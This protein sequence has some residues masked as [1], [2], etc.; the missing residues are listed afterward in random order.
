M[1]D[2]G[3]D[4]RHCHDLL[5]KLKK[6]TEGLLANQSA[7]GPWGTYGALRRICDDAEAILCHRLLRNNV[8]SESVRC[9]W[10][11]IQGLKWL[12]PNSAQVIDKINRLNHSPKTGCSEDFR[13]W[14]WESV[15]DHSLIKQLDIL[16]SDEEHLLYHYYDDAFLCQPRYREAMKICFKA[17]E[18]NKPALLA[19]ISPQLLKSGL[20]ESVCLEKN[21]IPGPREPH[22]IHLRKSNSD[23]KTAMG[24]R[25]SHLNVHYSSHLSSSNMSLAVDPSLGGSS[26]LQQK[27]L[28]GPCFV[29]SLDSPSLLENLRSSDPLTDAMRSIQRSSTVH[30]APHQAEHVQ[31]R[32]H[33]ES[34]G[35]ERPHKTQITPSP[36]ET[37]DRHHIYDGDGKACCSL[38][39]QSTKNSPS[40]DIMVSR[41]KHPESD[42][43]SSF[44]D[45]SHEADCLLREKSDS[46]RMEDSIPEQRT[47]HLSL[48]LL[49]SPSMGSEKYYNTS[50]HVDI[51]LP[52]L[53]HASSTSLGSSGGQGNTSQ[54]SESYSSQQ[55]FSVK[56]G[57]HLSI[58]IDAT[59]ALSSHNID[60]SD[61]SSSGFNDSLDGL[62]DP[63]SKNVS[64][65]GKKLANPKHW[66]LSNSDLSGG[67]RDS[68]NPINKSHIFLV[69]SDPSL[70][71]PVNLSANSDMETFQSWQC[72]KPTS[73]KPWSDHD[74]YSMMSPGTSPVVKKA[75]VSLKS[76]GNIYIPQNIQ[77]AAPSDP[78]RTGSLSPDF[79]EHSRP[80]AVGGNSN[81]SSA[82]K[83]KSFQATSQMLQSKKFAH[84]RW[85]SDT[86][87]IKIE[88][89]HSTGSSAG[90]KAQASSVFGGKSLRR[91][92]QPNGHKAY[93]GRWALKD[94]FIDSLM[95]QVYGVV[96]PFTLEMSRA[97]YRPYEN[98]IV[99]GVHGV[100]RGPEQRSSVMFCNFDVLGPRDVVCSCMGWVA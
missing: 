97:F 4:E 3:K 40:V 50:S 19:E 77:P 42:S 83:T 11:F 72:D 60:E 96:Y 70:N 65:R 62:Q 75:P 45:I 98:P 81:N 33:R 61:Q 13:A 47:P 99:R 38:C 64:Y 76:S 14:L 94:Y 69:K 25:N 56:H 63:G 91:I 89:G 88:S 55:G 68:F 15:Q 87:A 18:L 6:T 57:S 17:I 80:T 93:A 1:A 41:Q 46:L 53:S 7:Q 28:S 37:A 12:A 51:R 22:S 16:T 85:V 5:I 84:K 21:I 35:S 79:L 32:N 31:N 24:N 82:E 48:V 49:E 9:F 95:L 52:R 58:G 23:W 43:L 92:H 29:S 54:M 59:L 71:M 10:D 36:P 86:S 2:I 8:N 39:N 67:S 30:L 73:P 100:I 90:V 78:G 66:C 44:E 27:I 74:L 34:T 26:L 20:V